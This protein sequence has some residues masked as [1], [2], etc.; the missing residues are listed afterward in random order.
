MAYTT[1]N[2]I[3]RSKLTSQSLNEMDAQIQKNDES[4]TTINSKIVSMQND[5]NTKANLA[6]LSPVATTGSYEDLS[7]VPQAMKNPYGLFI[8]GGIELSY[9]GSEQVELTVPHIVLSINGKP[10]NASNYN[11]FTLTP[12]DIGA[13]SKNESVTTVTQTIANGIEVAKINGVPIYVPNSTALQINGVTLTGNNTSEQLGLAPAGDYAY[14]ADLQNGRRQ[15]L[16]TNSSTQAIQPNI[17][18]IF[19]TMSTLT[20]TLIPGADDGYTNEYSF[21]FKSG[22]TATKLSL[23][24]DIKF[25]NAVNIEANK[26]YQCN[27]F[28]GIGVIVG[29]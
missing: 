14:K 27:I 7:E 15:I 29:V 22:S 20:I 25:V 2:F 16:E 6:N 9:D 8:G 26:I 12:E 21:E 4:V 17:H 5:I 23:P 13:V 1:H 11:D 28:N 24:S 18:Y 10:I 3:P 19:G